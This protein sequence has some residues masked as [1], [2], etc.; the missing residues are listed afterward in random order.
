MPDSALPPPEDVVHAEAKI[1]RTRPANWQLQT[2]TRDVAGTWGAQRKELPE[3]RSE[4][5]D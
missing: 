5:E 1:T 3:N 4:N 2:A